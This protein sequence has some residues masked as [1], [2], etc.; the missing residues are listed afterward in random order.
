MRRPSL[1]VR[2]LEKKNVSC[3]PVAVV[4]P[5]Q[6]GAANPSHPPPP[7]PPWV[8]LS[9]CVGWRIRRPDI[10][11]DSFL[12]FSLSLN[13]FPS[14]P[15][16]SSS[17][18]PSAPTLLPLLLPC[19]RCYMS[20]W[21]SRILSELL[22]WIV[23]KHSFQCPFFPFSFLPTQVLTLLAQICNWEVGLLWSTFMQRVPFLIGCYVDCLL[24]SQ[25][26]S[27]FSF[28]RSESDLLCSLL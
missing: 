24:M 19:L 26:G 3:C 23:L 1:S 13:S 10:K 12:H 9:G 25:L 14:P 8:E 22:F 6:Q 4:V 17:S 16:F 2:K 27:C 7:S 5:I 15:I 18:P 20:E 11:I 28:F 21:P